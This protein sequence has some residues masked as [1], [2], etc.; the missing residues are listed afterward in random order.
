LRHPENS[1]AERRSEIAFSSEPNRKPN[2]GN[3]SI[4][5]DSRLIYGVPA[6]PLQ[7]LHDP[8]HGLSVNVKST[9]FSIFIQ[10]CYYSSLV[11]Y[12]IRYFLLKTLLSRLS[13]NATELAYASGTR[14]ETP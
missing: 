2:T 4:D 6:L 1:R 13:A 12:A 9:H 10:V 14:I 5:D 11:F 7:P 8:V 3:L